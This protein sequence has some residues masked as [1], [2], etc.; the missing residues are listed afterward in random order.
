MVTNTS[1]NLQP[2]HAMTRIL[3]EAAA[4]LVGS[5]ARGFGGQ[6]GAG[7]GRRLT[8]RKRKRKRNAG[9][10]ALRLV[11]RMKKQVEKKTKPFDFLDAVGTDVNI[12]QYIGP[13]MLRGNDNGDRIGDK[14]MMISVSYRDV[15]TL[16]GSEVAGCAVRVLH[17]YDRHPHGAL[18]TP[19]NI[20]EFGATPGE[21]SI[22]SPYQQHGNPELVG[23]FQILQDYTTNFDGT[24]FHFAH[25]WFVR[26]S[27]QV[28]WDGNTSTIST[29]QKGS[30]IRLVCTFGNAQV[31]NVRTLGMIK[32]TD[33]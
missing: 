33:S 26:R 9:K 4:Q 7:I 12:V 5:A 32:Y 22:G 2:K 17:I 15:I 16:S 11:K 18:P 29:V 28:I 14:I 30:L 20:L 19:A 6:V 25:K 10:E 13:K 27:M 31:L 3:T 23:R 24:Q 8:G 21:A 1:W